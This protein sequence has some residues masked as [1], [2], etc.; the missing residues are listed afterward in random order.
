LVFSVIPAPSVMH[1]LIGE[2]IRPSL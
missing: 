1:T 2:I